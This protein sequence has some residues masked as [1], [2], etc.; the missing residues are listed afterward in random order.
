M[1]KIQKVVYKVKKYDIIQG[2]TAQLTATAFAVHSLDNFPSSC[3]N[4]A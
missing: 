4:F 1:K 3:T 2:N